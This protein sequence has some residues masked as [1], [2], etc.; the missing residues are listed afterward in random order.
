[1]TGAAAVASAF[2]VARIRREFPV[3]RTRVQG[4]PL[5]YLDNG[6]TSQKPLAVVEAEGDFALLESAN[7]HRGVHTLSFRATERFDQVRHDVASFL[8]AASPSEIVFTSGTTA[9]INQVAQGFA[10]PML[11]AG[12]EILVTEMEHHS[13]LVPWQMVARAAG[14][15]LRAIPVTERGELDLGALDRVLT[16]RTRIVAVAHVSNVLG[17]LNPVRQLAEAAHAVGATVVVDGAQAVPHLPVDVRTLGADFY[18]ASAHKMYGPTGVG[19]LYGRADLLERMVPTQGGGGMIQRVTLEECT[20]APVPQR[21]EAGTPPIAQVVGLGAAIRWIQSLDGDAVVAHES[22]LVTY[23]AGQLASVRGVRLIGAPV[24]RVGVVSFVMDPV[25][26]HD[27]GTVLDAHGVAVRAGHHCAQPLMERFRVP[28]TV[29]A[30]FA[31]YNTRAE[32]DALVAGL[33]DVQRIFG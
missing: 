30:S 31:V 9:A 5:A 16:A 22:D 19:F 24:H 6:A 3:L 26:P 4:R 32:V 13:N 11:T 10:R 25:H 8:G 7:V 20:F 1:M 14:A 12:D 17:T 18:A 21:F 29:R 2:D 28:A 15:R 23:A 33:A 27:I